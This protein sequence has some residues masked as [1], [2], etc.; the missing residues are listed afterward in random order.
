MN[1][2]WGQTTI[3]SDGLN[4]STS[5]FTLSGGAYY[6]TSSGTGDRPAST[7]F[8]IEGTA[9]RGV[10]NGSAT[11]TSTSDINT[12]GYSGIQLAFRLASFS[13]ASTGNGADAGDIVTVEVSPN[14]GTTWY[15]TARVL[16]N[17]NAY[18]GYSATGNASTAYD[19]NA[20]SVDFAPAG[21]GSRT[22]DG[23]STVTV[24]SLPAT[25]TLRIRITMLNNAS[26]EEWA[27]DDIKIT[28]TPAILAPTI[29][30]PTSSSITD[31]S[32]MLGGNITTD[33]GS[34]I[35]ERGTIWKTSTGVTIADNKLAEGGITTGVFSHPRTSLPAGSQIF[36]KAYAINGVGTTLSTESSFYTLSTEP[37]THSTT[38]SAS[39][40]NSTQIGLSF[41]AAS[42]ITN[43]SGYLILQKSGSAPTGTPTDATTYTVGNTIGDGT[44]AAIITNTAATSATISSLSGSTAYNYK[45]I[46]YSG[47]G[48]TINYKTDGVIPSANATTQTPLDANSEISGPVL[49]SQPNPGS[50]SSLATTD[51]SAVRVLDMDIYDYGTT[52]TQP[53]KITQVTIK[54]GTNNTANWVNTIQGVKLSLDGGS[55]FVTIGTPVISASSIVIPITSGNLDIANS[56]AKTLSVY[57]YLKSSGLTDKQVLEFKVD[58]TASSHGFT[59]DATGS[60]FLSTFATAPVS[61]QILVDVTATKFNFIT[62]PANTTANT[63]FG[64]AVEAL[65]ANNNRDIDATTSVTLA[66]SA[67]TLSSTTGLTQNLASGLYTWTDL[68]NNTAGSGITL[69][70][71]GALTTATSAAFNI[72][73][74]K[75]TVQASAI[76]FSNV[77]VN[78][79]TV[80]WTNGD[81]ANRIVVAKAAGTPGTPTNGT[82]YTA[83]SAFGSG[84]NFGTSEY[85]VYNGTGTS[86]DITGLSGSTSYTFKVLEYNGTGGTENYL[87]TSN[88]ISQTTLGLTYYSTG[89]VDATVLTNWKTNRDGSG[90]SPANFTSG[91]KFVIQ[92]GHSMTTGSTW[93]VSGT[94]SKLWIENGGTLTATNAVTLAAATTFQIDNGGTYI[95]SNTSAFG[96]TIF[97]GI[98]S[99]ATNSTVEFRDW[100]TTGPSVAAWGNI[101][102]NATG[103]VAGSMQIAGNMTLINGNLDVLATGSTV[104]EIRF[105]AGTAPTITLKGNFTQSGGAVNLASS[106]GASVTVLNIAGNFSVSGGTFTS[107][108]TGSKVVFNGSSSQTFTSGGTISVVNF[109]VGNT[110]ILDMGTQ[111]MTGGNFT[112]PAGATLKTANATGVGGSITVS[113]TKTYNSAANYVLNGSS[114]QTLSTITAANNFEVNNSAGVNLN[115]NLVASA[116]TVDASAVLNVN[117]GKQLTA[118]TTLTNNG[119]L[120]LLSDATGTATLLTP[121]TLSGSGTYNVKQYLPTGRNSYI[122]SPVSAATTAALSSA[123]SVVSYNEQTA[124]WDTESG[125]LT[126]L[127]GYISVSNTTSGPITFSGTINNGDLSITPTRHTGVTKEGFNL[128]GNPYPS[129]VN[130]ASATKTNLL[131]TMWYRTRSASAYVFDTYNSTGN[132]GT[133]LGTTSVSSLIPPMQGFW[134]RVDAGQTSGTLGFTN[135][136]RS[137]ADVS[138]NSFKAPEVTAQQVLRLQVSNGE[139]KD[140]AI[141]LFNDAASNGY[142]AF[143][144]PK[145]TNANVAIPEIYTM[146]GTEQLVINGLNSIT[147][148]Q[149]LPLGFK[150]GQS[151][152]FTIKATEISNFEPGMKVIL[153]D[154]T[155][156]T[157]Q[158]LTDGSTY[159]FTSDVATTTTRFSV[160]F[161]SAGVT[162]GINNAENQVAFIYKNA[163]NQISVSLKGDLSNEAYVSVY[164][165]VGQKLH[166]EQIT[167]ANAVLGTP[168]TAGIYL[169]TVN[170]GGKS[171]TKKV[172][173]N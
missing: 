12:T 43:A 159:S 74:G 117:A 7:P 77:D 36:Y 16:G 31:I 28:G 5:L 2:S 8:Y 148:N 56:D 18:W 54:A 157:E 139:N 168:F 134:V 127:K 151:N 41:D 143:D 86:V 88:A 146:V 70:A 98:E 61:N 96:T 38:F 72:L 99:F 133:A 144:S 45:I 158:E 52:D 40:I 46:P 128:V 81:G 89:S 93:S 154:N 82:S 39:T 59:A 102:F 94:N 71:S 34:V 92:N 118:S 162:T 66:A 37:T 145:M 121:A 119:T 129:Y 155:L 165:A 123:S 19:G 140:E 163:N 108:S 113:G 135:A 150:T 68:Q 166:T 87:T 20:T 49:G 106:T 100:N 172:I 160:L 14:S 24:T 142:D 169:V 171:V 101:K 130:W 17:T 44:V 42:T 173:L 26:G 32:A 147:A 25:T 103:A 170:N 15:S 1:L 152:L 50:I 111:V 62:Q 91:E 51:G 149:E 48:A 58:A 3:A 76:T 90:S 97:Q 114:A 153:R 136:M 33:G 57:V 9:S 104:R 69:S 13:I 35:T 47:S 83:N 116:L 75:P 95:H 164:N 107:T 124:A 138:T 156:A 30:S 84:S 122:S 53:T 115:V 132:I 78:T 79:M 65:D 27:I 73:S 10:V 167:N 29:T 131:T 11:L 6:T 141:V 23:Y 55:T 21:G 137:H 22:T 67:G 120:N 126:P 161:K 109:E 125:A 64:T 105:A 60:T 112:L 80:S 110:S 63:N 85:V 4:S